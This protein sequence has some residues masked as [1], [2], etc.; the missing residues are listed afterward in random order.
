MRLDQ[1]ASGLP[2]ASTMCS[3]AAFAVKKCPFLSKLA[4][5]QGETYAQRI[6]LSP[7]QP[8][9]SGRPLPTGAEAVQK[10]AGSYELFHGPNGLMPLS[11]DRSSAAAGSFSGCPFHHAAA[12]A[13]S[14]NNS[15]GSSKH[16]HT[17]VQE[18]VVA[19][20]Q[21]TLTRLPVASINLSNFG[22][23]VSGC[24]ATSM[25]GT[26]TA[27]VT[28]A[29]GHRSWSQHAFGCGLQGVLL[30]SHFGRLE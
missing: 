21:S 18:H 3:H 5:E 23:G 22:K 27:V 16:A 10:L 15:A 8:A 11:A 29:G 30:R 1:K 17:S 6:A 14:A 12:A 13:A 19:A 26:L 9:G 25:S 4:Q 7:T 20:K 2:P 28:N 24:V